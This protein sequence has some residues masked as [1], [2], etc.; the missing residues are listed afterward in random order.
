MKSPILPKFK[1]SGA[2]YAITGGDETG[3][4]EEEFGAVSYKTT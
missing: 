3:R 4:H 2:I 1:K